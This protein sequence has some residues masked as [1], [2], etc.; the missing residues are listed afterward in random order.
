MN[1][2]TVTSTTFSSVAT[3]KG[4]VLFYVRRKEENPEV[5]EENKNVF[6]QTVIQNKEPID[7]AKEHNIGMESNVKRQRMVRLESENQ[8]MIRREHQREQVAINYLNGSYLTLYS[9][10][11]WCFFYHKYISACLRFF[12]F[13]FFFKCGVVFR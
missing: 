11:K 12:Y 9:R 2:N 5:R 7:I 6:N 10:W 13:I 1:N 8:K 4:Y 3:I